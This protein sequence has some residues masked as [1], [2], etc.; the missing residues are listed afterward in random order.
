MLN[1]CCLRYLPSN[2]I[3]VQSVVTIIIPYPVV[4]KSFV[5]FFFLM[6][7]VGKVYKEIATSI[8]QIGSEPTK[9]TLKICVWKIE[10][11]KCWHSKPLVFF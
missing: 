7:N 1:V 4:L 8:T 6:I 2:I 11:V 3:S 10:S 5:N 9:F